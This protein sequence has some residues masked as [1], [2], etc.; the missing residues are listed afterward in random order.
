MVND[1]AR[2]TEGIEPG[3]HPNTL[4]I[5][6]HKFPHIYMNSLECRNKLALFR[7]DH[8]LHKHHY[9]LTQHFSQYFVNL[10]AHI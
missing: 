5:K 8:L 4:L 2:L 9:V 6:H 7:R 1:K 10:S 3:G